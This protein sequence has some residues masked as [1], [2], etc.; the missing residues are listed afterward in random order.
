MNAHLITDEDMDQLRSIQKQLTDLLGP[1]IPPLPQP[2]TVHERVIGH[3]GQ[4]LIRATD[5][6]PEWPE[7][8]LHAMAVVHEEVGELAKAV[9]QQMYE[10]YKNSPNAVYMEAVQAAAMLI[11]FMENLSTYSWRPGKQ[12]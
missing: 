2:Q 11:R 12:S 3:I 9:L 10:P 1:P 7:D 5:K 6:F 4:E 8:P